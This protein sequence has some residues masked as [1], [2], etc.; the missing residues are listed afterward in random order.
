MSDEQSE[1]IKRAGFRRIYLGGDNDKQG[2]KLNRMVERD[3]RGYADMYEID[4]G[5][6]KDANDVLLR[7]GAEMLRSIIQ[8]TTPVQT[9]Y[10]RR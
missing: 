10:L 9:I 3:M 7:H 8:I 1:V 5:E 2:R 6:E 4:Y